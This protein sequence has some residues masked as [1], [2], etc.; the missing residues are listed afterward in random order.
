MSVRESIPVERPCG[1]CGK[2]FTPA[3][4][5]WPDPKRDMCEECANA[6]IR[7]MLAMPKKYE[8]K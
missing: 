3:V 6:L 2:S 1:E 4:L 5:T 8:V 7:S